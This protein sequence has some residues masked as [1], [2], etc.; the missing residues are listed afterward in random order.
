MCSVS[1]RHLQVKPSQVPPGG[2]V[3][4][5]GAGDARCNK[6]GSK[7]TLVRLFLGNRAVDVTGSGG[8]FS[9]Q[10]TVPAGASAGNYIVSAECHGQSRGH[11]SQ[12]VARRVLSVTTV[13][14]APIAL[15]R[16][17]GGL[18]LAILLLS[19]MLISRK[20]KRQH[21]VRWVKEH[22][23]AVAGSSPD[24]PS[25]EIR[26]RRGTRSLSLGLEPHDDHLG[27]RKN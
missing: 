1:C 27:N 13:S 26:R 24:P 3:T 15:V 4:V 23:L 22:L 19:W 17:G 8:S 18:V 12:R 2:T 6:A 11:V 9:V 21:D 25:A 20:G 5:T 14:A 7:V 16:D 10:V